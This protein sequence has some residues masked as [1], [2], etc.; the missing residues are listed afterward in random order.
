MTYT[1]NDDRQNWLNGYWFIMTNPVWCSASIPILITGLRALRKTRTT[2]ARGKI[3]AIIALIRERREEAQQEA[4]EA[5]RLL[6]GQLSM[7]SLNDKPALFRE[8]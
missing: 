1:Q 8:I 7:F 4:A 6:A 2:K 5:R 3:S